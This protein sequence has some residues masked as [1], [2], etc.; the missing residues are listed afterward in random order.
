MGES[1]TEAI[2]DTAQ[3]RVC[4]VQEL[5]MAHNV[6]QADRVEDDI[7]KDVAEDYTPKLIL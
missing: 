4:L 3:R 5:S 1:R 2:A 7:V 6:T